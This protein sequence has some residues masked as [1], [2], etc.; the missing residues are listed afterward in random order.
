MRGKETRS[1]ILK[2]LIAQLG[3]GY[4]LEGGESRYTKTC[5]RTQNGTDPEGSSATNKLWKLCGHGEHATCPSREGREDM[6]GGWREGPDKAVWAA[7]VQV[8]AG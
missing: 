7:K 6:G 3:G 8:E 2:K 5:T 4:R 1:S